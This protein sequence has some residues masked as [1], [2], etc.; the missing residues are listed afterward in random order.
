MGSPDPFLSA[1]KG[2]GLCVV[3]LPRANL[4]PLT[5]L[6]RDGSK[7]VVTGVLSELFK[8]KGTLPAIKPDQT[9]AGI[10]GGRT[11]DLDI[12]LGISLLEGW[13]SSIKG[14]TVGLQTSFKN[15]ASVSFSFPG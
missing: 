11:R 2:F 4:G 13:L 7:L 9:A 10:S 5:V 6:V 14:G 8:G 3:R 12:N 1:L 15:A